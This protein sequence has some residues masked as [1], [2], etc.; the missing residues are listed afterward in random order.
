MTVAVEGGALGWVERV[1]RSSGP[2]R[3]HQYTRYTIYSFALF[4]GVALLAWVVAQAAGPAAWAAAV[5]GTLFA[6]HTVCHLLLSRAGLRYYL[7]TS[8]RPVRLAAAYVVLT[9]TGVAAVLALIG[10]GELSAPRALPPVVWLLM[11]L[12]G[13]LPLVLSA[14][15]STALVAALLAVSMLTARGLGAAGGGLVAAVVGTVVGAVI[16]GV[17][18]RC[19]A[20]TMRVVRELEAARETQARLAVAE[21]RL[22]FGRDLHDVLGRNLSVIAL[23]SELAVQLAQRGSPSAVDQMTEVQRIAR[24]SQ[25]EMRE[26]VRGYREADLHTELVGARGVLRAAGIDCRIEDSGSGALAEPLQSALGWV[27]REGTT[28]VLRHADAGRCSVRLRTAGPVAE[29]VMENDGVPGSGASTGG[30]S[31]LAGLRERLAALGGT[32]TGERRGDGTFRL[33][34]RIPTRPDRDGGGDGGEGGGE[35]GS[36]RGER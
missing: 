35:D 9:G 8:A 10:A 20:W 12:A 16:F 14:G 19:S 1:R 23:K 29:L 2:V 33:T 18:Y 26:V 17:S 21:E 31:G 24:E 11:F 36:G 30:G 28:N 4:E 6:A 3:F 25:R 27:V 34:A 22:R 32:L 15:R 5:L 7:G 13:P